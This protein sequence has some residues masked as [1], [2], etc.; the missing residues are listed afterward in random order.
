MNSRTA[1][2]EFIL[3][4]TEFSQ[5]GVVAEGGVGQKLRRDTMSKIYLALPTMKYHTFNI[6][7]K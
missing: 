4:S 6:I 7:Y 2:A 1:N 5:G 3:I